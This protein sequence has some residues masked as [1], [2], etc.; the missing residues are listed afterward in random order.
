MKRETFDQVLNDY[1]D[2]EQDCINE[3]NEIKEILLPLV[4][5]VANGQTLNKKRLGKFKLDLRYGMIHIEGKYSHLIGYQNSSGYSHNESLIAVEKTDFSRGFEYFDACNGS[6][7]IK[8][9]EQIKESDKDK[10][11]NLF[12]N[13]DIHFNALKQLF[14]QIETQNFGSYDFPV[15]YNLL[16]S[17]H[18]DDKYIKLNDFYFIR[19]EKESE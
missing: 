12:N 19:E 9:I 16:K 6:A 17:I 14:G 18:S 4:G 1:I 5:K 7:A 11:F 13:I 2:R 8:R 10:A 3:H 15:Y